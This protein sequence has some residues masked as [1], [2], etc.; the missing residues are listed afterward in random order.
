MPASSI[1]GHRSRSSSQTRMRNAPRKRI[2]A[3]KLK[4]EYAYRT[5]VK[6]IVGSVTR[7]ATVGDMNLRT[8]KNAS[9]EPIE[10]SIANAQR[11]ARNPYDG[12]SSAATP[13]SLNRVRGGDA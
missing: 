7:K 9:T 5:V 4:F 13:A 11:D 3:S 12:P 1:N 6:K 2:C 8:M 10:T